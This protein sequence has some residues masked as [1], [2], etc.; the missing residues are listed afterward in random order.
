M[1][2]EAEGVGVDA[3]LLALSASYPI[4]VD[5]RN[6]RT[7][8]RLVVPTILFSPRWVRVSLTTLHGLG[9]V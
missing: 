7:A 8:F 4:Y 1:K 5:L 2:F 9:I 3:P 6:L